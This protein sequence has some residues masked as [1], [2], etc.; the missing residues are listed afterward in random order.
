MTVVKEFERIWT[1]RCPTCHSVEIQGK[2]RIG[3]TVGGGERE[4]P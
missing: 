3:G 2:N 1:F 4:R